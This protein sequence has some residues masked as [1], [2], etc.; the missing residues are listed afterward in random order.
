M[1]FLTDDERQFC[2]A[3][4]SL[5]FGNPFL[6][7][8]IECEQ[9]ALG[10]DFVPHGAVW[11]IGHGTKSPAPNVGALAKRVATL[12]ETV[13]ARLRDGGTPTGRERELY[14]DLVVYHLYYLHE[15][16][17]LDLVLMG[18]D[19]ATERLECPQF[20]QAFQAD[21]TRL[22]APAG[23]DRGGEADSC[24]HLFACFHQIRRAFHHVFGSIVGGSMATAQLRAAIWQS[25]FT[26]DAR[27]YRRHLYKC[28]GDFSVLITGAS[29]TGK[30]IVA[31][32]I[33]LSRYIPFDPQSGRFATVPIGQFLGLSLSALSP[34][35]VESE[36]FG[37]RRGAFTGATEDRCGWLE[38]CG[39][40]G[41]VFLDEIGE[42]SA[43]LQVKLLRV[44]ETRSFQRLGELEERR[45]TGK[46]IAATNRDLA[47]EIAEGRFRQDLYYRLCSD[48]IRTPSLSE[49]LA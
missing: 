24:A 26:H 20:F 5:A 38:T 3:V 13:C 25:I 49:Q 22:L 21:F 18:L 23:L 9:A 48:I 19:P 37:H 35:L 7:S 14:H 8:R 46:L 4:S 45:F 43:D 27:R 32:S 6:H 47:C 36:L 17:F 2:S 42:I 28:M 30:E 44:L 11:N 34:A 31:M 39:P 40:Q 16:A 1:P 12:A 33:A 41:V 29:G 15:P 10:D